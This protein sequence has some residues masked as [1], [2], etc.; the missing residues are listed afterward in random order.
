[1]SDDEFSSLAKRHKTEDTSDLDISPILTDSFA[2][3]LIHETKIFNDPIHG[4]IE[5]HWLLVK[6][7]DTPQFQRLRRLKQLGVSYFVYPGACHQRFEHSIG[8]CHLAGELLTHLCQRQP[9]LNITSTDVLSVQIAALC[10]DLG[11]GPYSHM[12]EEVINE[13]RPDSKWK[14][15]LASIKM[16]DY[17]IEKNH[18]MPFFEQVG[19]DETDIIFIKELI[20]FE[21]NES[22]NDQIWPYKGRGIEKSFL[23]EIV[24]NKLTGIDV[25]KFDYFARDSYYLGTNSSFEHMRFI[26][27]Y[28]VIQV[29]DGK[30]HLCLRDKEV[31]ACYE[32]YRIRD[33][34]HRRAYQHPV[35]KGI[36]L[37]YKEAFIIAN[38][39]LFFTN[40]AGR[41][42]RLAQT[43]DD[44]YTF[45]QIDDHITTLIQH[46][47]HPNMERAKAILEKVELREIY[48][49]IGDTHVKIPKDF[50]KEECRSDCQSIINH[51]QFDENQFHL[52][53]SDL[54]IQIVELTC[55]DRGE[56]PIRNMWFYTK[57]FPNKA[58]KISKE[59][60]STLLP[61]TF[62]EHDIRLYCKNRD[63][64]IC[65]IVRCGF[66]EFCIARGYAIPKVFCDN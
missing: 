15:E 17:M 16:L 48:R 13:L 12:F 5:L 41:E 44:M 24:S 36:E 3:N 27:F 54:V 39:Y 25:D 43:I 10:H 35:V 19:L 58:T 63:P 51:C 42:V 46:S 45:Q 37:M 33:D 50:K 64:T 22:T 49:Y 32:V 8:T 9:E 7:I 1:M 14:H 62:R 6:L 40:A 28:R 26:K 55:G 29:D 21:L 30:R 53:S 56:D 31:K 66:K 47:H 65:S 57:V 34:L 4:S 23:Y 61:Q 38:D 20:Y 59:Q 52:T 18:L 60:V 11:H 2:D